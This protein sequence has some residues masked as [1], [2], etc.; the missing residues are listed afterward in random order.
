MAFTRGSLTLPRMNAHRLVIIAAALP[1]AVA[2]ALATAL[3]AFSGQALP[4]AVRH[5]LS[6]ASG[7]ALVMA[8]NVD[9]S[10]G[11]QYTPI[12]PGKISSALAG[13]PFAFY[14]AYWS[15]PL[16]FVAGS[17]PAQPTGTGNV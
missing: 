16:G 2:A 7:T 17:R 14:R 9:A 6:G 12:L 10:P 11:A 8:G 15:D 3:A 1:V 5:D 4:H 13:T